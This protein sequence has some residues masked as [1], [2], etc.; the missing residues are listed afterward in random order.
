VLGATGAGSDANYFNTYGIPV[1]V[2][3]IGMSKV[4][5]NDE[6]I[7]EEDLYKTAEYVVS[8]IAAAAKTS[9]LSDIGTG[10]KIACLRSAIA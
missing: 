10:L 2:L 1:A 4:H 9:S 8:L 7:K 6:Y 5:T 3:G